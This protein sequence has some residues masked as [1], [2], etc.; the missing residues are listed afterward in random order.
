MHT[1][2]QNSSGTR[3]ANWLKITHKQKQILSMNTCANSVYLLTA[4]MSKSACK[5]LLATSARSLQ[6]ASEIKKIY[7]RL[8]GKTS[9]YPSQP[10]QP[11]RMLLFKK[12][13]RGW[14]EKCEVKLKFESQCAHRGQEASVLH[15]RTHIC[16]CICIRI[17]DA[18]A[19]ASAPIQMRVCVH[20]HTQARTHL[21][22]YVYVH[23]CIW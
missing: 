9:R 17:V 1:K 5:G 21:Y 19:R 8:R 3:Y 13:P 2:I 12:I 4:F 10:A 15:T 20:A 6:W 11:I 16:I 18:R 7:W 23:M 14:W 22:T